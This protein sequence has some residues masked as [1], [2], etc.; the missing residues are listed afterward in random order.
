M[1]ESSSNNTQCRGEKE[2]QAQRSKGLHLLLRLSRCYPA[3][4]NEASLK[5]LLRD[6]AIAEVSCSQENAHGVMEE[7]EEE[8]LFPLAEIC[9]TQ[10]EKLISF[11]A[12]M[13]EKEQKYVSTIFSLQEEKNEIKQGLARQNMFVETLL[14]DFDEMGKAMDYCRHKQRHLEQ[15]LEEKESNLQHLISE[16]KD[17]INK[18]VTLGYHAVFEWAKREDTVINNV[19]RSS[20][21]LCLGT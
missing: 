4:W 7:I 12:T 2:G 11:Q 21:G 8:L 15:L 3:R 5:K 16:K 18:F 1:E 14:Q 9:V 10:H 19:K 17:L 6:L 20:I 13:S